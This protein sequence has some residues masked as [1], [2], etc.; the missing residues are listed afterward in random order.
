MAEIKTEKYKIILSRE[1]HK[2]L[3][4]SKQFKC[5]MELKDIFTDNSILTIS[6]SEQDVMNILD[7]YAQCTEYN[8][9]YIIT[10]PIR[11]SFNTIIS[12]EID[13]FRINEYDGIVE[14]LSKRWIK[15][16]EYKEDSSDTYIERADIE[17]EDEYHLDQ[18]MNAMYFIFLIDIYSIDKLDSGMMPF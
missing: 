15:I 4:S 12:F 7:C 11:T 3:W 8:N 5:K 6:M 2:T 17:F 13:L 1:D 16:L 18:L 10:P 14:D 9:S